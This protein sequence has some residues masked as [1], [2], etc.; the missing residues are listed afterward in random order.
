MKICILSREYP[1]ETNWGGIGIYTQTLAEGL[2]GEGHVVHVIAMSEEGDSTNKRKGVFIHRL[3]NRC[4]YPFKMGLHE[5]GTRLE[6]SEV[7][8]QKLNELIEE[9]GIEVVESPN[10]YA[11][12]FVAS[13][14]K[15]IPLITRLHTPY[16]KSFKVNRDE[17]SFDDRMSCLLEDELIKRSDC[18][19]SSTHIHLDEMESDV[20]SFQM[21]KEIIPLGIHQSKR[22]ASPVVQE[23][24][25]VLFVGR[26]EMRKGVHHLVKAIPHVLEEVGDVHFTFVGKNEAL[27]PSEYKELGAQAPR[28]KEAIYSLV[29]SEY[30]SK[31]QFFDEVPYEELAAFYES[32]DIFIAPS[33]YES[34]GLVYVEAMSYG[35]PVIACNVGGATEIITHNQTGILIPPANPQAISKAILDLTKNPAKARALGQA[36]RERVAKKYTIKSMVDQ[37]LEVY[38]SVLLS[39]R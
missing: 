37:T 28:F 7:V 27:T 39:S 30:H 21:R 6:Y 17:L 22:E 5:F 38:E 15:K 16:S 1:P 34:F 9:E 14:K 8:N 13:L 10:F 29:P 19:L 31:M 18:V 11:E 36:A 35:K 24:T 20:G 23:K 3:E 2:V 25:N 33:L 26:L 32:C 4:K 12:G